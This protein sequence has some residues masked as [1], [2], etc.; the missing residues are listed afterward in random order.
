[1][2]EANSDLTLIQNVEL[3]SNLE[4]NEI[5]FVVSHLEAISLPKKALLFTMGERAS[6]FYI[7]KSGEV[8]VFKKNDDDSEEDLARFTSGDTIGDFDFTRGAK[9]DAYAEA[10]QDSIL[11]VFPD[12]SVTMDSLVKEDPHSVCS[13]LLNA[14]NMMT[15]RIKK[16][17]KLI[18]NNMS[19]V[20]ELHRRAYE[21]A[22]T[23]L[24]KQTLIKDEII[25]A[26]NESA[27]LIMLKPDRFKIL[28]DSRG[29]SAGDEAMSRIA[30]I[31]KNFSRQIEHSWALRFKSNEVGIIINNCTTEK[32]RKI[33]NELA[34]VIR[35][36]EPVQ[37][38]NDIPEFN[39]TATIS[40]ALWTRES[41]WEGLFNGN[42]GN[43][44]DNWRNG[45][46]KT[47]HYSKEAVKHE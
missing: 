40:W 17:H 5:E 31:L 15:G 24:W 21:D 27:G 26:L 11:F 36:M 43:L 28:V 7:L 35:G 42:Y 47:I 20:Q 39:F 46:D 18:L 37:A 25:G 2:S 29:H 30:I 3:F 44:L 6:Q 14:I 45:G 8:R 38:K 12:R 9:Y 22:G 4:Q 41:E 1:M 16:T 23:G 33:A 13:I 34:E 19:W 10:S 32:A